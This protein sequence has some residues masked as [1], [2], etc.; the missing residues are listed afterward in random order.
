LMKRIDDPDW[1][2]RQHLT[3]SLGALPAGRRETAI[4][5]MLDQHASDPV[6]MDASLSGLRGTESDALDR[7]LKTGEAQTPQRDAAITMLAGTI[8][9]SAQDTAVQQLFAVIGEAGRPAWQRSALLKGAEV[10]LLGTA[11]PGTSSGRRGTPPP[12][13]SAALPCP[14]CPG[15]RAGPGG[16]YA[17]TRPPAEPQA[18]G[19]GAGSGLRLTSEPSALTALAAGGGDL[20]SRAGTVLARIEWP[21]KPGAAAPIAPLT[22]DEQKRFDAGREVYRNICQ[23]CHQPD[24]RGQDRVAPSLVGSTLTLAA[25]DIP[26]RILLHGKDGPMGLMPPIGFTLNDEQIASV[27]TYV[28]R[29]WGQGGSP[30]DPATVKSV[31]DQNASRTR[32]WTHDELMALVAKR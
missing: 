17:F 24:G 10:A 29:E 22:A 20:A 1:S 6:V 12:A 7:L 23:G 19:R 14:T 27:L 18:A 13:S 5:A 30:V 31:R 32:P 28:R 11:M 9:R 8:V 25:P 21:G 26:A 2:V 15:G 4:V 3:A 16:A